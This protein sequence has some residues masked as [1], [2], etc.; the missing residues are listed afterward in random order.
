MELRERERVSSNADGQAGRRAAGDAPPAS[1]HSSGTSAR[2]AETLHQADAG[3]HRAGSCQL[4]FREMPPFAET[5]TKHRCPIRFASCEA[6]R[7]RRRCSE[8]VLSMSRTSVPLRRPQTAAAG[9]VAG[10]LV[11][12][13]FEDPGH[14]EPA[15]GSV[16]SSRAGKERQQWYRRG[17]GGRLL[18]T[19]D[20]TLSD[21]RQPFASFP[22]TFFLETSLTDSSVVDPGPSQLS[23][24]PRPG[25]IVIFS[26]FVVA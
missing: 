13:W 11:S 21:W 2:R 10:P 26:P 18:R 4:R 22:F 23:F 24:N 20:N 16:T 19:L 15:G 7:R 3:A 5:Q 9:L 17:V 12:T 25:I 8:G 1:K 6:S 14:Q